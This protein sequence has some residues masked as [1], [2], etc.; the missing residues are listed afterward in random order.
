MY[1]ASHIAPIPTKFT[2]NHGITCPDFGKFAGRCGKARSQ[3]ADDT[4]AVTSAV[5]TQNVGALLSTCCLE[6]FIVR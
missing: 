5:P 2:V 4:C 3:E 6:E 1:P